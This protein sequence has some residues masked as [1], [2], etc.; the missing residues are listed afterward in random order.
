MSTAPE[1]DRFRLPLPNPTTPVV[2]AHRVVAQHAHL[3]ARYDAAVWPLAPLISNPSTSLAAIRWRNCSPA[4]E[5]EMRLA[6]WT[7]IN[8]ELRPTFLKERAVRLRSRLSPEGMGDAVQQ[9]ML[10]TIWLEA[11][12]I[13]TL[14][15][16]DG[17]VLRDYG[18]HLRDSGSGRPH[19]QRVL[20]WLTRLWA[21]DQLSARPAGIGRPPWDEFG[22]DDFLPAATVVGG[23][24]S[25]E[26][27]A[28]ATMGPLLVWAIRMIDDLS[29]DILA[30]WDEATR[31]INIAKTNT[32][33]AESKAALD[34][35]LGPLIRSQAALPSTEHHGKPA[36]AR[37]YIMGIT[38]ASGRQVDTLNER[39]GLT[40]AAAERPGPCPLNVPVTGRIAGAPWREVLDFNEASSL[41]RHLATAAFIVCSYLTGMRPEEALGMVSGCCPD[42]QPD[43]RGEVGR[44]LIHSHEWKTA[45][46][47]EGNHTSAGAEREVPWVAITPV[48]NAIRVLERMVPPGS[49]LFD[50]LAHDLR[51]ARQGTG[52]LKP[53]A[54]RTR[55]EEFVDWANTEAAA[56]GLP[57]EAIASD[58]HG[59]IGT[60]RFRR[61][62]AWHIARRP[63]GLVALAIQ[64]GH[65]RTALTTDVSG[66]YGTR[67]RDGIHNVIALETALATAETAAELHEHF[68]EGG[69]VSGP[70]ARRALLEAATGPRFEGREVKTDFVRKYEE[71][72][73]YLARDGAVIYENPHAL[74]LCLY[75]QDRALCAR[76]GIKDAPTL[77]A[78]VPGCGNAVRTDQHA[79]Q[80]RLR[81][82]TLDV[83]AAHAPQPVGDRLR[84]NA[85]KLRS[86]ATEHDRTRI[87]RQEAAA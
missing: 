29:D 45:T 82:N 54:L 49:L 57:G 13:H 23:E 68:E 3:N 10:L 37:Q 20:G 59:A 85:N 38:G 48:V 78:C 28:E 33:T 66:G 9:W 2:P 74:L 14:A 16:C 61:S 58:P 46:D 40:K 63:G 4:L 36:L 1:P 19:V 17:Q 75:K 42:P 76:D 11:R 53:G 80:L 35:Y 27:L 56:Q 34:A 83:R 25:R 84:A 8:G 31:L 22:A 79:A 86:F 71:A 65:M 81:A 67:S 47:E 55:I 26:P 73:K 41:M 77:D 7:M 6:V 64:Y 72:R 50:H 5:A 30:A 70:A 62:L 21:F 32:A 43:E 87:T 60:A 24:N 12:G 39:H 69:G 51:F 44:H 15:D 18:H 52:S